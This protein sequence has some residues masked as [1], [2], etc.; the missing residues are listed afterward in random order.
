MS[1]SVILITKNEAHDLADCLASV[2]WADEI[3]VCDSGSTDATLE[4][5]ERFT[6]KI[7]STDWPGFGVQK[8]RALA[9]ASG[10]WVLS[11]DADER[12]T[13]ELQAEIRA[14]LK[15]DRPAFAYSIPRQ[16]LYCGQKIR[17]GDW[18]GDRVT[19][20]F[21]RGKAK[22]SNSLVHEALQVEGRVATL[23]APLIHH[24]FKDFH[25]VLAKIDQ[26]STLG[27]QLRH[28]AGKSGSFS[29]ALT[30]ALWTFV[31]GYFMRL[32]FLD[33]KAGLQLAISNAEGCYYRYLKLAQ[34]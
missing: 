34:L 27:A 31:R 13:P 24:A 25:E 5:A 20:L 16:S 2:A 12:V 10:D 30:H 4:I 26:Y 28:E 9:K 7:F 18:R 19:R 17:F 21:Q 1:L 6:D 15:S 23:S 32:G 29:Q 22:F 3:I 33:G 8:N 14:V 11:I